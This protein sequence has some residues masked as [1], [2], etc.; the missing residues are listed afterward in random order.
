MKYI[1]FA[2]IFALALIA[3][4]STKGVHGLGS[5]AG[6]AMGQLLE[7]GKP[8]PEPKWTRDEILYSNDL[9]WPTLPLVEGAWC[10]MDTSYWTHGVETTFNKQ[11]LVIDQVDG[12]W[13]L[14]IYTYAWD[15]E[16]DPI[17]DLMPNAR[18]DDYGITH[19]KLKGW[20]H[21]I[22]DPPMPLPRWHSIKIDMYRQ[23]YD[24]KCKD[25]T[26]QARDHWETDYHHAMVR[27]QGFGGQVTVSIAQP[28]ELLP[29]SLFVLAKAKGEVKTH[30]RDTATGAW[31]E[32]GR[33]PWL[34]APR[35][36]WMDEATHQRVKKWVWAP[37]GQDAPGDE[38]AAQAVAR[39]R[40]YVLSDEYRKHGP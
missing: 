32:M 39:A 23:H 20:L 5:G 6:D 21:T 14:W 8:P 29:T 38:T 33:C 22:P 11:A 19:C 7:R 34:G 16:N 31:S 40:A 36:E 18:G 15:L 3:W 10:R 26:K 25:E 9:A 1:I 2:L 13:N 28:Y 24:G 4:D 27:L 12:E 35:P 30:Y 17:P 37:I